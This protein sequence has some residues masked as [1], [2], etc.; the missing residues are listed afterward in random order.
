MFSVGVGV[1]GILKESC[2]AYKGV[3]RQACGSGLVDTYM[4]IK[5]SLRI[6]V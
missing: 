4:D 3:S 5:S 6:T 2:V 1:G